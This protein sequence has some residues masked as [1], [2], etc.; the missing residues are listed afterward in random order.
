MIKL[1]N[2]IQKKKINYNYKLGQNI[3]LN[4]EI[5][6]NLEYAK[7]YLINIIILSKCLDI[8]AARGSGS[9]GIF[10]LTNGFRNSLIYN[11]GEYKL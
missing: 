4:I 8:I 11:L 10:I 5:N 6:G 2:S 1:R 3:M 7:N 9:T